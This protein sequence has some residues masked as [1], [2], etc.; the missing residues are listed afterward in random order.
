MKEEI[1]NL[2]NQAI[3]QITESAS[4]AQLEQI[5][6]SYL[7]KRGSLTLIFKKISSLPKTRK[8]ELG[9]LINQTKNTLQT[10]LASKQN[11][12]KNTKREWF[13]PTIPGK[14]TTLG[15]KHL[16][17]QAIEEIESIFISQ[18]FRRQRYPEVEW[19]Y[20]AFSALNFPADHPARDDMETF[21]VNTPPHKQFGSIVL[22][23]HTSNGQVREIKRALKEDGGEVN[24]KMV[25]ISKTYRR[26]SD[27]SHTM[28]FHQTEGMVVG[29][30]I[31]I[32]HLK[33]TIDH[34][35]KTYYRGKRNWRLR[36][37]DFKFTEPSFEVDISCDVCGGKGCRLCKEGWLELAGA[38]LIHPN[39][40]KE[41]GL[42]P[43]KYSGFA[44]G[45]GVERALMMKDGLKI[46]D[47]RTLYSTD[48]NYL[49]QF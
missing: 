49:N 1:T 28:M 4:L 43:Q 29:K 38:G 48:L 7:G 19:D 16:I 5:R 46:P 9:I 17:T 13:D 24:I 36:P 41:G 20:Y 3:A 11:K 35:L 30:D 10:E 40:L 44:F 15:H 39:V 27:I 34:F 2:R 18:G 31:S 42:S 21:F 22:T 14:K 47:L 12:I 25:N 8:K 32:G 23:P 33:G 45:F 6:A 37:H 26:Q